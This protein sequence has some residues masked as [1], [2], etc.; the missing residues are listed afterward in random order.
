M[1]DRHSRQLES[2]ES[3]RNQTTNSRK[4]NSDIIQAGG[5]QELGAVEGGQEALIISLEKTDFRYLESPGGRVLG[6]VSSIGA[7]GSCS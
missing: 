6:S 4:P 7:I 2:R 1:G 5:T 3:G